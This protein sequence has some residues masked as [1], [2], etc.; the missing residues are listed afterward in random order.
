M[1]LT[2]LV[3]LYKK[4][5]ESFD[6]YVDNEGFVHT[7]IDDKTPLIV[8]KKPL[9][10]PTEEHV[11]T[12]IDVSGGEVELT[13][14]LFNPFCEDV[15]KS[16]SATLTASKRYAEAQLS[17][18]TF[19]V[20]MQLLKLAS[21]VELQKKAGLDLSSFVS[22]LNPDKKHRAK[23][24]VSEESLK[25]WMS[26]WDEV[27]TLG[28]TK[29]HVS[30]FISKNTEIN[31]TKYVRATTANFPVYQE[32]KKSNVK[33]NPY[34]V[35][36]EPKDFTVFKAIFEFIYSG[37]ADEKRF[38]YGSND[39]NAPSFISLMK[40]YHD[41]GTRLI[42]LRNELAY[43]DKEMSEN[44]AFEIKYTTSDLSNIEKFNS[45]LA[46]IPDDT[47]VSRQMEAKSHAPITTVT[48]PDIHTVNTPVT[49]SKTQT[50][51]PA[52]APMSEED[53]MLERLNRNN[54]QYA[55]MVN[56]MMQ[57]GMVP[58]NMMAAG[59]MAMQPGMTYPVQQNG[60]MMPGN[61]M[62]QPG[63][64]MPNNGMMYPNN[65]M[66]MQPGMMAPQPINGYVMQNNQP[67][68][69]M[70]NNGRSTPGIVYDV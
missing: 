60:M 21:S 68:N 29:R 70:V 58:N 4:F 52:N 3:S 31:G 54:N 19:V 16:Q 12:L 57:P 39:G 50:Q 44:L 38:Y 64:V 35:K 10:L 61:M 62:M 27:N 22:M 53:A 42:E 28:T 41:L 66:M 14:T 51:T 47:D 46:M 13:K 6:L 9:V 24:M 48:K 5:L 45:E 11:K 20:G 67:S 65:N 69:V 26:L 34:K 32:L 25:R 37:L 8:S 7:D 55:P 15:V 43:V 40:V 56:G 1:K 33:N 49:H 17:Y 2:P 63:M 59:N 30:L 23:N 18:A 36:L